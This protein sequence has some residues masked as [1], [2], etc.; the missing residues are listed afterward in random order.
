MQR[1]LSSEQVGGKSAIAT[2]AIVTNMDPAASQEHAAY[3]P[4]FVA[5]AAT[6]AVS[7]FVSALFGI[8]VQRFLGP[9][10]VADA[11][12]M[13]TSVVGLVATLLAVVVGL[14][15]S[16]SYGLFNSQQSDLET[17]VRS[18]ARM[19]FV[20]RHFGAEAETAGAVLRKQVL[21]LKGRLWPSDGSQERK[22]THEGVHVDV[23]EMLSALDE[24][25][26]AND[27]QR[28]A[29]G[30]AREIFGAFIETQGS[31]IRSL[32]SRVP[33][34]LLNVVLGWACALFFGYGILAGTNV[35]TLLMAAIGSVAIAS[36]IFLILE[37]SDPYTG[38]FRVSS[39]VLDR[40]LERTTAPAK[41]HADA[42][43]A[44]RFGEQAAGGLN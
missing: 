36:A 29:L 12:I 8:A 1:S 14:L 43:Q 23:H 25:R 37:L 24:L 3:S 2:G 18:V 9:S 39:A 33:N 10:Y 26:P 13:T 30:Q 22:I 27:E 16:T 32:A 44:D 28:H 4:V 6:V 40:L 15:V 35:L 17:I 11:R 21:Q 38:L 7:T 31:M 5:R 41:S 42:P 34:L 19:R 20:L